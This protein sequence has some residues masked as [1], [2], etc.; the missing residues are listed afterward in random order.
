MKNWI[1]SE[2]G[3]KWTFALYIGNWRE[4]VTW[5]LPLLQ[6]GFGWSDKGCDWFLLFLYFHVRS[7]V[8]RTMLIAGAL[9]GVKGSS[10]G[11]V[12][13]GCALLL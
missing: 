1:V 13:S 5:K 8:V 4:G 12:R 3:D 9:H 2:E 7:R 11:V 10:V 6:Q